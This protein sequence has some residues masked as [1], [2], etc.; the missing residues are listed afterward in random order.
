ME[1]D[2]M[3]LL[4]WTRDGILGFAWTAHESAEKLAL[5]P[6]L[7]EKLVRSATLFRDG[8]RAYHDAKLSWRRGIFLFGPAGSGKTAAGRTIARTLAWEHLT[9]PAHEILDSHL[10]ERALADAVASHARVIVLE[11]IDQVVTRMETEVFF[12]LLDHA[13]E[14]AEGTFWVATSRHPESSPKTQLIR[15]G[16]FDESLRLD[17]PNAPVRREI[18]RDDLVVPFF[19]TLAQSAAEGD[20]EKLLSDLVARTDGLSYSHFEELRSLAARLKIE[21]RES[22]IWSAVRDY[23]E[24]QVISGDRG[25]GL[26]D[27]TTRLRQRVEEVDSRV[28]QAALDMTDVFR[29]LMEKV[30]GDAAAK[31]R[32]PRAEEPGGPSA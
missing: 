2:A 17:L 14:R 26:S 7:K 12:T 31:A 9:I 10:L 8:Q 6:P 11:D 25:G 27:S 4:R 16:R 3:K 13:M 32:E 21:K 24:D 1:D 18:L 19:A 28:L 22:E 5:S 23:V 20:D 30:I 15:P 29:A